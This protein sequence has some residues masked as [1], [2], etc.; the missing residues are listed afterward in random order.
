VRRIWTASLAIIVAVA[1]LGLTQPWHPPEAAL[2]QR[3]GIAFAAATP[4]SCAA[5][6]KGLTQID[7]PLTSKSTAPI[8]GRALSLSD[9][10]IAVLV[11]VSG[12]TSDGTVSSADFSTSVKVSAAIVKSAAG[13]T[14]VQFDPAVR[15][16]SGLV[17]G[18]GGAI[19]SISFCYRISVPAPPAANKPGATPAATAPV[20]SPTPVEF[21]VGAVQTANAAAATAIAQAQTTAVAAQTA[22]AE[23]RAE[24]SAVQATASAQA[25]QL[26]QLQATVSAPTMTPTTA[27]QGQLVFSAATDDAFAQFA[28]PAAGWRVGGGLV[29]DGS[30]AQDWA[31]LPAIP[32]LSGNQAI[33]AEIQLGDGGVCPRNFG[34]A[35]RGSDNGFV[36]GGAEW[37]CDQAVKLWAGQ[38]QLAQGTVESLGSGWHLLRL[39]ARGSDVRLLIDGTLAL[40]STTTQIAGAQLAIW[41]GGVPLTV[42]TVRVFDLS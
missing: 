24:T 12:L 33:E 32:G 10:S 27:P 9:G 28:L 22:L 20:S 25:S 8:V 39:E 17:T 34:L 13:R 5:I 38:S 14:L 35:V 31:L 11:I 4:S 40:E 16:K 19:E 30:G 18:D 15:A 6:D 2:L 23:S 21:D 7:V 1:A 37:A 3:A 36:A 42:R 41:S 26:A 29:A